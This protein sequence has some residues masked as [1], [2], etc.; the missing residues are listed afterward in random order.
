MASLK[1]NNLYTLLPVASVPTGHTTI[2]SRWVYKVKADDLHKG[3]VVV[4]GWGRLP[5]VDFDST[6]APVC[7]L[8]SIRIVLVIAAEYTLEC[9]QLDYNTALYLGIQR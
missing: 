2:G 8:Q 6:F 3:R 4:L 5:G 9:W 1:E 7:R